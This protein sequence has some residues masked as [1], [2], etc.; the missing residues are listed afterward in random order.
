VGAL[1]AAAGAA[2]AGGVVAYARE[3]RAL[4][5]RALALAEENAA[6]TRALAGELEGLRRRVKGLDQRA[7]SKRVG[8]IHDEVLAL[9]R[10]GLATDDVPYPE[11]LT[12]QRLRIASQNEEDGITH[13][14]LRAAGRGPG[15]TVEIGCGTNGGNT[16][17]LVGELGFEGLMV[18]ASDENLAGVRA[19]F[20][21]ALLTTAR[22]WVTREGI[23]A[24]LAEHGFTGEVDVL[25]IDI[26]GND[27]WL[28]EAL[29]AVRPRIAVVEFNSLFGPTR[30]VAVPYDPAFSMRAVEGADGMYY[31]ASLTALTRVA[32]RKGMRLV[33]TDHRGVNAFFVREGLAPE[34]PAVEPERV[35]RLMDKPRERGFDLDAFVAR[36]GLSLAEVP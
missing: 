30:S 3:A 6:G 1:A 7:L 33:T 11:R 13:A 10:R 18:D 20:R 28:W 27:V 36:H 15:R 32:R 25:S 21:P 14:L 4:R 23:D 5:Q 26:D 8:L 19:R 16:G 35:W 17:F 29:E 34:I 22:A 24:L 31:G 2:A 9:Q 12:L